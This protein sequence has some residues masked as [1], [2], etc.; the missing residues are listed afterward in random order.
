MLDRK[1]KSFEER[2]EDYES[3]RSRIF[4]RSQNESCTV[5]SGTTDDDNNYISWTSSV[6]QQQ[7]SRGRNNGKVLKI[8]NVTALSRLLSPYLMKILILYLVPR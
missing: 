3:T 1:A 5:S 2:E 8:Q 4:N 6:D 7:F